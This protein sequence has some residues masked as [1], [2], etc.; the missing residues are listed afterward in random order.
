MIP[1]GVYIEHNL[2]APY[3]ALEG[4]GDVC[5]RT[6]RQREVQF[7]IWS[8]G[9]KR[10]SFKDEQEMRRMFQGQ[11]RDGNCL[12]RSGKR[13]GHDHGH[14]VRRIDLLSISPRNKSPRPC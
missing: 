13:F 1:D 3:T 8:D 14:V 10:F 7:S 4:L 6:E 11:K 2:D 9:G 12:E 5:F